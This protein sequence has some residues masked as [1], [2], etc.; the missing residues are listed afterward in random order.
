[1]SV[2]LLVLSFLLLLLFV[3]CFTKSGTPDGNKGVSSGM[4]V[5]VV[6]LLFEIFFA[7]LGF[8]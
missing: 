8:V 3:G 2:L 6:V 1:M 4:M 5:S 7:L